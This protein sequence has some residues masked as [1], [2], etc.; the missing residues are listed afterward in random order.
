MS[1]EN[2]ELQRVFHDE[3]SLVFS[4]GLDVEAV[5]AKM[6]EFWHPEVEYDMSD[7]P[8]PDIGGVYRGIEAVSRFWRQW[9]EAWADAQFDY[10][11]LDAGDHVVV[12]LTTRLTGRSTGI[13]M[14]WG[15]HAFVS[16][17]KDGL[18]LH[19]KMYTNQHRSPQS[20]GAGGVGGVGE[21]R[22]RAVDPCGLGAGRLQFG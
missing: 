18:I 21:P 3:V 5:T 20:R 8:V 15:S 4:Q 6:A 11:V 10:Q 1:R 14:H 22:P 17:Y 19:A 9:L 2:V 16:T 7:S 13:E 12:L